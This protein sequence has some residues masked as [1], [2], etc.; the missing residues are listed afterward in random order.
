MWNNKKAKE[1]RRSGWLAVIKDA[2]NFQPKRINNTS[3]TGQTQGGLGGRASPRPLT[4]IYAF[5]IISYRL[6]HDCLMFIGARAVV[7]KAT[8][9]MSKYMSMNIASHSVRAVSRVG[10]IGA[11]MSKPHLS[12]L[13]PIIYLWGE[14]ER[15]LWLAFVLWQDKNQ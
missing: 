10:M 11:N 4:R 1:T 6:P 3:P 8:R 12:Y 5:S 7:C 15:G 14:D 2:C 13:M 9:Y